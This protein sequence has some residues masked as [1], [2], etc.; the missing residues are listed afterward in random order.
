MLISSRPDGTD[1]HV[2][3]PPTVNTLG[4]YGWSPDGTRIAYIA[5]QAT[6]NVEE[7]Y[8][9]A[10]DGSNNRKVSHELPDG[11]DLTG[12]AWSPD[13]ALIVY[14]VDDDIYS[15]AYDGSQVRQVSDPSVSGWAAWY[16]S[17]APVPLLRP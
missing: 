4:S 16:W 7:I 3:H 5:D 8:T 14:V 10:P 12:L 6:P 9:S 13:G 1:A 11:A 15:A 17:P 2:V